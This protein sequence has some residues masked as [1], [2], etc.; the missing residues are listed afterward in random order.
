MNRV[1]RRALL[2]ASV[3]FGF[4][5]GACMSPKTAWNEKLDHGDFAFVMGEGS[6]WH[7]YDVIRIAATGEA[8]YSFA[9]LEGSKTVWRAAEFRVDKAMMAK[10]RATLNEQKYFS[11]QGEY[12]NPEVKDGTQWFVKVRIG[13]RKKGVYC[14]NEFPPEITRISEFV[15]REII[16]PRLREF[17]HAP[18][19][20]AEDAKEPERFD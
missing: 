3:V 13:D 5:L 17:A 1:P 2:L 14:D 19:I 6:G 8:R 10:L 11:L 20:D 7:G 9:K 15:H 12:R 16:D 4:G 18:E